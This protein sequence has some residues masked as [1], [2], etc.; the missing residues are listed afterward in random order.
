MVYCASY[1]KRSYVTAKRAMT[2]VN[3]YYTLYNC[4]NS[5]CVLFGST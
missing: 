4:G 5:T 2:E 3:L 1:E